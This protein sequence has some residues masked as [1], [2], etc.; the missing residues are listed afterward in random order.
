[1]LVSILIDALRYDYVTERDTPFLHSI[2]MNNSYCKLHPILGYSDAIRATIFT[3]V[4]PQEHGYWMFYRFNPDG[5]PFKSIR[6]LKFIENYP[7]ILKKSL[8]IGISITYCRY[9]AKKFGYKRLSIQNFPL[10]IID[11]FDYTLKDDMTSSNVF[12]N[13]KAIF[14]ILK[15]EDIKYEYITSANLIYALR[16][17]LSQ[18]KY[19]I[20]KI[21][22]ID[23]NTE[24]VFL[25]LHHPDMLAHRFGINSERFKKVLRE[26]DKLLEILYREFVRMFRDVSMIIFSD[27]GMAD[28]QKF[29]NFNRLLK[30][31]GFGRDYLIALDS[32][33]VRIWYLKEKGYRIREYLENF[34]YGRFL[35]EKELKD[36][37]IR[38]NNRW[39]FDDIYLIDPPYNIYPNFT[40][41]L[42]PYAMHAYHPDLE[43]QKGIAIFCDMNVRKK[44][45]VELVDFMPTILDYFGIS[46]P[47]NLRG[48]SLLK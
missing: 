28:A 6:K 7:N 47:N 24:F 15:D 37:K 45:E 16:Y 4:Y 1:M 19:L 10:N 43:S 9:L 2:A 11:Y 22:K 35:S 3:G 30:D 13:N 21:R 23:G 38:F 14:D 34:N 25:Y 5:S 48:E 33:M 41:L 26:T 40:S 46:K 17:P 36:L 8:K 18:K 42:K 31:N 32:T 20:S 12:K 44:N 27:H 29:I 39:Y